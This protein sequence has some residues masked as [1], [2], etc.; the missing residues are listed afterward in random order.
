ME[1]YKARSFKNEQKHRE[2][3]AQ[4]VELNSLF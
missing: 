3:L 1:I 2:R 4:K